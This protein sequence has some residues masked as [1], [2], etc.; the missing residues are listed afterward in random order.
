MR[1]SIEIQ[2][3]FT[4]GGTLP[5][6]APSY[7]KRPADDE[8]F[9]RVMNGELC[10]VLTPR[11]MGKSS[12]MIR[13]VQ[14]LRSKGIKSAIVDLTAIG[15]VQNEN[16]WY[17]GILTQI[18]RRLGV[19]IDP[20]NWWEQRRDI[21]AT[22][23]FTDFFE[24]VLT[25]VE[26]HIVIFV[27]EIDT[28]LNLGFRD[29]F[30][31]GIRSTYNRRAEQDVFKRLS[32]VLLGV[33]SPTD[34]ISDK[35][36]TPFNIG[37]AISLQELKIEDAK[38]LGN[39]LERIY[40]DSGNK[41]LEY[42]FYWTNGHPYLTQKLCKEIVESDKNN[43]DKDEIDLLV[44][45]LFLSE[46]A[47]KET[48]LKFIQDKILNDEKRE[49]LLL[50]YKKIQSDESAIDD[51]QSIIHSKIKISGL[52]R[53]AN[54]RLVIN[55]R[56]YQKVFNENWTEQNLPRRTQLLP[57]IVTERRS[58]SILISF[59][60]NPLVMGLLFATFAIFVRFYFY[61]KYSFL[62]TEDIVL[63]QNFIEWF[64]VAYGLVLALVLVNVWSGF[65][66]TERAF[67]READSIL[68]LY[69]SVKRIKETRKTKLLKNEIINCVKAYVSHVNNNYLEEHQKLRIRE[70]GDRILEKTR[71]LIGN[72]IHT[73]EREFITSELI[74]QF[75]EAV[76]L[77]GDR[78]SLSKQR[79][80]KPIWGVSLAASILW[81]IPFYALNF[82][83]DWVAITLGGGVT[84]IV[85]GI[86]V[87]VR[88]LSD[89]FS[90]TWQINN[91]TWALLGEKLDLK[92]TLFFIYNIENTWD[93]KVSA[94][95]NKRL[96]SK[97]LCKLYSLFSDIEKQRPM[98][99]ELSELAHVQIYY[100]DEFEA[101]YER[102]DALPVVAYKTSN[103]I[104]IIMRSAEINEINNLTDLKNSIIERLAIMNS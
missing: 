49:E 14:R 62:L 92:P 74:R 27:D 4:A 70:N 98:L 18:K 81:L 78:I 61:P 43:W 87:V 19:R 1:S 41:I 76:D 44:K 79:L 85:I 23:K 53:S 47:R 26:E 77:R 42:V 97:H 66:S 7:V 91:M 36:R 39:E 96:F 82:R 40:P 84:A 72:L 100:K 73:D 31:A 104:E 89:P 30:F 17:K 8:L 69:E 68:M 12:L 60:S 88:D 3:F 93:A 10:Y 21:P 86:L 25:E 22:Q 94:F 58:S 50:L 38:V 33:A 63:I 102:I 34:L 13:T 75:N 80:P 83:N 59:F 64:G 46:E 9:R 56:I 2:E 103:N 67:D 71:D 5:P 95:L 32:F 90:G 99:D 45:N 11:Q 6:D 51:N 24:D 54:G 65:D 28:T 48:N 37:H 16:Q 55:N 52:V 35:A 29:D 20:I 15:T 57:I 101:L